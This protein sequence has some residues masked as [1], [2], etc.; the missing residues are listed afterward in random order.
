MSIAS[1]GSARP[2]TA[3]VFAGGGSYGAVQVGMLRALCAHDIQPDLVAG[4]SVGAING[5]F[6][7]ATP[8]ASGIEGL[9]ALWRGLKRRDVFPIALSRLFGALFNS[10]HLFEPSGL[11][12]LLTSHLPY[13]L[14]E[15]SPIPM[16]VV[17]TDLL[18][19]A[20]VRLSAGPTVE[21]VLA[22]CAIPAIY[23]PVHIGDRQLIDGAVACNTPIRTAIELGATRLILLPTAFACP[24]A[25]PPRGVFASA[26]H[27][28]DLFVM[29]QLAQDTELYAKQAEIITVPPICPLA[30]LPYDFSRVGRLIDLAALSTKRWLE[31]DGLLGGE[32]LAAT[33]ERAV[34]RA[35]VRVG[36][37]PA[38]LHEGCGAQLPSCD[39]REIPRP[40]SAPPNRAGTESHDS[41]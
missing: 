4:S 13:P 9:E 32:A 21:A 28:M 25:A 18:T 7:A 2:K 12:R 38:G 22:S 33:H 30:V 37:S 6:Y 26:F 8:S 15:D 35:G 24:R 34:G 20:P 11:R 39:D 16:H 1:A 14:L 10:D 19:G 36:E 40:Q 17:A 27:A 5:A 31:R 41:R 23:P 29:Q 3:F